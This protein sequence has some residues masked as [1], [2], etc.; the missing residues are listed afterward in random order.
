MR[1]S[2]IVVC[3]SLV[4]IAASSVSAQTVTDPQI[5]SIV[6]TANQVDI[7]AG[8]LAASNGTSPEVK[9][10][11]QQMVTD[12]TGVNK[13]ATALV[14]RLKV[15]PEDNATSQSLKSGGDKNLAT[16]KGLS[17]AAFDKAYIDNEVTYHQAVID[18]IDKTL[19]PNAQNADLKTLLVKV[20]PAFVAHMEHAKMIQSSLGK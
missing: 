14:T 10:F 4:F 15:T 11:G 2:A 18:A 9:K 3:A 5:A 12:H 20:R 8:K 17:G 7:D 1:V 13:Q 16:L 19:I 6:V